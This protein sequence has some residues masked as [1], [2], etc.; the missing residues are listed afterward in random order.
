M[1]LLSLT[2]SQWAAADQ[3]SN[4]IQ[5][6]MFLIL[7][8]LVIFVGLIPV[9]MI[10]NKITWT[11][12]GVV[13][14]LVLISFLVS[15]FQNKRYH[16]Y[17]EQTHYVSAQTRR[18]NVQMFSV[19]PYDPNEVEEL[20][21]VADF[22]TPSKLT[23]IYR[24]STVEQQVTYLGRDDYDVYVSFKKTPMKFSLDD[25]KLTQ[26][27]HA[28]FKGYRFRLRDSGFKKIGF[29]ALPN[30]FRDKI[31]IPKNIFPKRASSQVVNHYDRPGLVG[32]WI[33]DSE[34]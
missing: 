8:F 4:F 31:L 26:R 20:R 11:L 29:L 3:W 1:A 7:G 27:Q 9:L 19:Q 24:R 33:P 2:P 10:Q 25:V 28:Y 15:Q 23:A 34:K 16:D 21:Y 30:D 14:G 22:S 18:Y 5:P 6:A 12:F 32:H 17:Y 13:T